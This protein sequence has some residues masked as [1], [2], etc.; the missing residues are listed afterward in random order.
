MR[1][2]DTAIDFKR[3]M[4]TRRQASI[5]GGATGAPIGDDILKPTPL[6]PDADSALAIA[7]ARQCSAASAASPKAS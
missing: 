3:E 4:I 5:V 6:L 2:S 7:L 1:C